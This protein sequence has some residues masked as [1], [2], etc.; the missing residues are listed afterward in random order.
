MLYEVEELAALL[1]C[2][3]RRSVEPH[4]AKIAVLREQLFNLRFGLTLEA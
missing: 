4:K 3:V 1:G 2:Y